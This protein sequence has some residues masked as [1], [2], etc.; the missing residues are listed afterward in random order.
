[1]KRDQKAPS[2]FFD[3]FDP[4]GSTE[5]Q[6]KD[7]NRA[8]DDVRAG[9]PARSSHTSPLN[10]MPDTAGESLSN[11]SPKTKKLHI[12]PPE[13]LN[14]Q[15]MY[16]KHTV[17]RVDI[18]AVHGLGAIPDITWTEKKSGT[19]WLSD[20][21]M[22]PKAVPEARI[23]RFG[24]DSLWMGDTPI[25][26]TL[27]TIATKLLLC[28][29][30][31]RTEDLEKPLLFIGHCFGGLVIERALIL[32]KMQQNKYPSIFDSTI[33]VVFLGTPH[34]GSNSFTEESTLLTA[35][36][37]S[38]DLYKSLE[39]DV[40]GS[41]TSKNGTLLDVAD[42]F[43]TLCVQGGPQVSCFFEQRSSKLGKVIGRDDIEEFIVD[44]KSA[45]FD[46]HPKYGLEVDH[47]SL[48]K[49]DGPMNPNYIQVQSVI[50]GYYEQ[51]LQNARKKRLSRGEALSPMERQNEEL[52]K[53]AI[54]ELHEEERQKQASLREE[55]YRKRRQEEK[56]AH[57][58]AYL[59]R[60]KKN[61]RKYG[62][63][64][65]QMILAAHPLPSDE[66][67]KSTQEI[68]EKSRWYCNL[69]KGALSDQN[70]DGGQIDEILNDMGEVMVIDGIETTVTKMANK[71][72]STRTLDAYDIPW[73]YDKVKKPPISPFSRQIISLTPAN[74]TTVQPSLSNAGCQTMS[75]NSCGTTHTLSVGEG[76]E[77]APGIVQ[78]MTMRSK[79]ERSN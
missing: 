11:N 12:V 29:N 72:V 66:E 7:R 74:R 56:R 5:E 39:T 61:M 65:P 20:E 63:E 18:V 41:M 6:I 27:S 40:L 32:A 64:E 58:Q 31:I 57:E 10:S 14:L 54:K 8:V 69:L 38:S 46:G 37:A 51:A 43:I 47:F 15:V 49:F 17:D 30:M 60:L 79:A 42:D 35:I 73:Q 62:I 53:E 4:F 52:R 13:Q 1:M 22:L 48:N 70:L 50:A 19:N 3:R 16:S 77:D 9:A 45:S 36:A 2:F 44:S 76:G 34:R 26:T 33:G 68:E 25:R 78:G 75:G 24:Y 23:L 71:W 67:L 28:L 59:E 21:T 55:E